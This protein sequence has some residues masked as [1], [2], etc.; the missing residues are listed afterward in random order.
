MQE[1]DRKRGF[2][3]R[4]FIWALH[5]YFLFTRGLTVG[6]RAIVRSRDGKFLLVRHTYT[7]GWHLPG[8]GVEKGET[9]ERA[10]RKELEQET[11][12]ELVGRPRLH[13]VFL[14]DGVSG[15]D[16][17]FVY[18]CDVSNDVPSNRTSIEIADV[19]YFDS[20]ELPNGID[21]GTERRIRELIEGTEPAEKW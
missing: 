19:G 18:L 3:R 8:G 15:R 20:T 11:G 10:L 14:N 2:A 16:H 6:V 21:A 5:K 1:G 9:I 17:V 7:P 12:L 4:I 13:G